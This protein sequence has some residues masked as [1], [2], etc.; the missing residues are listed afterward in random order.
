MKVKLWGVRG[1]LPSPLT[2][3]EVRHKI[4][5]SILGAKDI[6]IESPKAVREYVNSL[7][8]LLGG[9][10]G[11]NTTCIQVE[12]NDE[13][14]I[15]DSGS[16]IRD[17]GRQ[18]LTGPC[19]RGEGKI[20][21]LFSH[22]HWDHIQGF[23]FFQPAFIKGNR[24]FI[25]SVHDLKK[26]LHQQQ[27]FETFPI[28]LSYMQ[29]KF[30]FIPLDP[31]QTIFISGVKISLLKN[32]HPG[33]AYSFRFEDEHSVFVYASDAEYK[34]LD[35]G[36]L[37][38]YVEFF[39]GADALVFDSQYTLQEAWQ[40]VDW[41]HSSSLIGTDL[42]RRAGVKRLLLFHH[43]PTYSDD[44]L[45][46]IQEDTIEYQVQDKTLSKC[47]VMIA[48]EG[49]ELD[50]TPPDAVGLRRVMGGE[51]VL[52]TPPA[53]FDEQG[54]DKL[55]RQIIYL[56]EV[57][58]PSY[59][60]IDLSQVKTLAIAGLQSLISLRRE[61]TD[62]A[63]ALAGPSE[64]V[65]KV[66]K[67]T[68]F[69]EFFTIYTTVQDALMML[70]TQT[71]AE[72]PGQFLSNRYRI[73]DKLGEGRIGTVF[74]TVDIIMNNTVAVKIL[75]SSFSKH[76]L[77]Q[78]LKYVRPLTMLNHANIIQTIDYA[79][80]DDMCYIVEELI[81]D[82][83]TL[84]EFVAETPSGS[85]PP[86][87]ALQTA[88][89]IAQSLEYAHSQGVFHGDLTPN[90]IF[91]T[92]VIKV[93]DFGLGRLEEGYQ[94][95]NE[96]SILLTPTYLAPEQILG[97]VL[98]TG[99]DLYSFG[100][101]LY[102]LFTGSVP[103][104]GTDQEILQAHLD[105]EPTP[106]RSLNPHLSRSLEHLILKLLSKIPDERYTSAQQVHRILS[107]ILIAEDDKTGIP[108]IIRHTGGTMIGR[109]KHLEK[110]INSWKEI[111]A[112]HG[113]LLFI[114][115]ETGVGKT[116]LVQELASLVHPATIVMGACSERDSGGHAYQPFIDALQTY[117]SSISLTDFDE[118]IRLLLS[119]M[120]P[121]IPEIHK[122]LPNLLEPPHL[123]PRQEQ[124]RFMTSASKFVELATQKR[125]WL[126]ILDNLHWADQ[127]SLDLLRYMARQ[128]INTPLLIVCIYRDT[129]LAKNQSL[130]DCLRDLSRNPTYR[131]IHLERLT[132]NDI[133]RFLSDLW[134][135]YV[136]SELVEQIFKLTGGNPFYI[137]EVTR[138]L[139]DEGLV[140]LED[141]E[142]H[143]AELEKI[144]LP[145]NVR[146]TVLLHVT[147]LNTNTHTLLRQAAILGVNFK[148]RELQEMSGLTEWHVLEY[149]DSAIERNLIQESPGGTKLFFTHPEIQR[150]FYEDL[151]GMR[152]R[153]LHRQAGEAL[154]RCYADDVNS[155][156]SALSHHF[157]ESGDFEKALK[158]TIEVGMQAKAKYANKLALKWYRRALQV[159]E[160]MSFTT[161][162]QQ[163]VFAI[164]THESLVEVLTLLGNLEEALHHCNL[165]NELFE[166]MPDSPNKWH[167]LA[168]LC[169]KTAAVYERQG[170]YETA[171][172]KLHQG[173]T[174]LHEIAPND[175]TTNSP[176]QRGGVAMDGV[177]SA[178]IYGVGAKIYLIQQN[179]EE[180][181]VWC[182]KSIESAESV[183]THEG[184]Q[185]TARA[186]SLLG[187]FYELQGDLQKAI[188]FGKQSLEKYKDIEDKDGQSN[189]YINLAKT[190]FTYGNWHQAG[191]AWQES[192]T[193]KESIGDIY[194]QGLIHYNLAHL[195]FYR[196]D[197]SQAIR[198]YK[199]SITI[200]EQIGVPLYQAISLNNIALVYIAKQNWTEAQA[201]LSQCESIFTELENDIYISELERHWALYYLGMSDYNQALI[202]INRSIES[203]EQKENHADLG[204]SQ[205]VLGAILLTQ[206]EL[207]SAKTALQKSLDILTNL[208]RSYEMAKTKMYLA[209]L[210]IR[211]E[212]IAEA[213]SKLKDALKIYGKL[214]A[215]VDLSEAE[216]LM[217]ML[218]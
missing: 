7:P 49:L 184:Y 17:L 165:A 81:E 47:E 52:I 69:A 91:V 185:A 112:G 51:G 209:Q 134:G 197:L 18:L 30:E 76:A 22:T 188:E 73:E 1:S 183:Q 41:G 213:K 38:P 125:A 132:E 202:Y 174:Y 27:E 77:N 90:N 85:L 117:L 115:G 19:G 169:R 147:H 100:V 159:L 61:R 152:R 12:A 153:L 45:A 146:D 176:I 111:Q 83:K 131:L 127:N 141:G 195:D 21:L 124:L 179:I 13:L 210:D 71:T 55:E 113:E 94:L 167:N 2:S 88:L 144:K 108:S 72:L 92:D 11:G 186:L 86:K 172:T 187:S 208:N 56:E 198:R 114:T 200:M 109:E 57:G 25:Y 170:E 175:P 204:M 121:H 178:H 130:R 99:V 104:T 120:L 66:I 10:A 212:A 162:P 140:T 182:Q 102:E 79:V 216:S 133:T 101:I 58:W 137:E 93:G 154:E 96:S 37:K 148:F 103:F 194:G 139:S 161:S 214:G 89:S 64:A 142:W 135:E 106:P 218:E 31:T 138:S 42:A 65:L 5:Q 203:A 181:I 150:V 39:Q 75:S 62:T 196:G 128:T 16:G 107:N 20:H 164:K 190:Y 36:T 3:Q 67:I 105:Q 87:Q 43:D 199:K 122:R 68:G 97:H 155:V 157:N 163:N 48:Y 136:P 78:F 129:E 205:R 32:V 156:A 192:L 95:L 33:D 110:L 82:G 46:Q 74:K 50:L 26:V 215:K 70:K 24:I 60:V 35:A 4:Y 123:E 23:P 6:D 145:Q 59:V 177:E 44:D 168:R 149:L 15:I 189:S 171:F 119:D 54:V 28:P 84:K 158:Y 29:A 191:E 34:L 63:L 211:H 80:E 53:I 116:R 143:F 193:I 9:T 40:K 8:P 151:S 180:G 201:S 160:T 173:L 217:K 206:N 118:Q 207:D 126:F 98:N 166:D 14:F